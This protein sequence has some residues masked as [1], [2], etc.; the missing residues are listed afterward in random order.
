MYKISVI[1]PIYNMEKYLSKCLD[2]VLN[3]SLKDIEV[4]AI[5]DGSKDKSIE[6]LR[7]YQKKHKN[8]KVFDNNNMGISA[9][10]NFGIEK[11]TGEYITFIDSDDFID[12]NMLEFMYNKAKKENLDIVVCDYYHYYES[13]NSTKEMRLASFKNTDITNNP[14]LVFEINSSPW[15]K[16][17]KRSLILKTKEKFPLNIKYEDLGY[18]PILVG[19]AK[20]IGKIDIPFNYYL[21]RE[22]SET[23]TVDGKIY[24]IFKI[25]D[26]LYDYYKS[27]KMNNLKEVEYL[28]IG[29]LTT[30]NLQ[31]KYS[32]NFRVGKQFVKDSFKYL[33]T[34]F[35]DWKNNCYFK[36]QSFL[37]YLI[38]SS[39]F[40]TNIYI[41]I[42]GKHETKK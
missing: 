23:T 9:T 10:R 40:L 5:N 34:K 33:N 28:F 39:M 1:I 21:I 42:G 32:K 36:K 20:K 35:P 19:N 29:K 18:I 31:Q 41:S 6:I 37:K 24:D 14:E 12:V 3:Q 13:T 22:N 25:L 2:S 17:Y 7:K 4:I 11:S 16:I 27:K 38:K 26:I 15:N 30:Y 8:L